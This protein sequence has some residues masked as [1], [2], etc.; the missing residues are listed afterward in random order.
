MLP[1]QFRDLHMIHWYIA[2]F[3]SDLPRVQRKDTPFAFMPADEINIDI[4]GDQ[5]H[6]CARQIDRR[7]AK[8]QPRNGDDEK[9][10]IIPMKCQRALS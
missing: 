9:K 10:G 6:E 4:A 7:L 2:D 5:G 1:D 3:T 8:E